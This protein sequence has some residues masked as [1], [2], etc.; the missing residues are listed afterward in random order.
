MSRRP[1]PIPPLSSRPLRAALCLVLFAASVPA[2]TPE[3]DSVRYRL[4]PVLVTG[5]TATERETPVT[6]TDVG[7]GFL[8]QRYSMQDVPVLLAE[9]PSMISFSDGGNGVG[10]NFIFLRGFDQRRLSIMVNGVPQN[11]PEDHN[12]YWIDFP[13]LLAS[14]SSVQIQRGA[15]SAF[16]G[17]PAIGGSINIITNPFTPK[18][19]TRLEA[20]AGFQEFGDSSRPLAMTM[21]K[22]S[23]SFSS[24][25]VNGNTMLYGRVAKVE[26]DGYRIHS[27]ITM[28][29][30]FFGALR[31]DGAMTTRL[32]LFGGP[33][34]DQ[35]VYTGLPKFVNGDRKLR[36]M[37]L[38]YWEFDSAR[39][40][41]GYAAPRR[42]QETERFNQPHYELINDWAVSE[43]VRLHNTL[44]FYDSHGWFDYDASWADAATLRVDSTYGFAPSAGFANAIVRGGVDLVQW[45][46]LSRTEWDHESGQLTVGGEYRY[47]HGSH[48]GQI[49]HAE[50]LPANFD[51][52]Y[53]FYQY[54]GIKHMA[55]L[56][57]TETYRA[58]ER[59]TVMLNVQYAFN[60]YSI[61]NERFL[62]HSF[63][64]PYHFINPRVGVNVNLDERWS[65]YASFGYTSREPR[66]RN[67]YAA[68]DAYFG[69]TPAFEADTAGGSVRYDFTRPLA[70]PERLLNLEAGARFRSGSAMLNAN[71][72]WMEFSDELVKS[73]EVDVFGNPVYGNAPRT[74]HIGAEVEWGVRLLPWL[75]AQG[76]AALSSN[77]IVD[78]AAVDSLSGGTVYR[79][80]LNGNPIAGFPDLLGNLRIT[81]ER[82]GASL[83]ALVKYVGP[84]PTD[85]FANASNRND[86]YTV[87]NLEALYTLPFGAGADLTVRGEVRNLFDRLYLQNGEGEA[88]FPAAERNYLI[89]LTLTL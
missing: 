53:R 42:P 39:T 64:V 58:D 6:F 77:T 49:R 75:T 9:Q 16:Y 2:Q 3:A 22:L 48:W 89:G 70:K 46:W 55:S 44:F 82:Q 32:H 19:Y 81:A 71:L 73:G 59:T 15:G 50:G 38:S 25:L 56:Y 52:D 5:T 30:Y 13:D 47:H 74:R 8:T 11:D 7:R 51:P 57:V 78:F 4:A 83:S 26:S 33:I 88:F 29:S 1:F 84:F 67:L 35:L 79:T 41:Y 40:G 27:G 43:H 45:G 76:N 12:V 21:R 24:G 20:M 65:A 37:N 86:A 10:Y 68:E 62:G 31:I 28:G 17:P 72:Y 66:L 36:R 63:S 14:A 69:A 87:V 61:A 23:A 85:N 80:S 18:P 34:E 60:E 54:D